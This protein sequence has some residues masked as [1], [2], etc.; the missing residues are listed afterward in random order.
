MHSCS[1]EIHYENGKVETV[2]ID[3]DRVLVG[4]GA[5]CDIRLA[6]EIGAF[7]HLVLTA[8]ESGFVARVIAKGGRAT[9][10]GAPFRTVVMTDGAMLAIGDVRLVYRECV[11]V[12]RFAGGARKKKSRFLALFAA[13]FVP[14]ATFVALHSGNAAAFGPPSNVPSPLAEPLKACPAETREQAA[15]LAREKEIVAQAKRQRWKFYTRDGV[16]AVMLF[17]VASACHTAAGNVEGAKAS[18]L[19]ATAMRAGVLQEFQVYRVRLERAIE[20][21]DARVALAQI[22]FLRD[23]L[24]SRD[25]E[26]DYVRWLTIMQRKLEAKA[27]RS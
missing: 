18:A 20:R 6:P 24:Y 27:S 13:V 7:E 3:D 19:L 11:A 1:F 2:V 22:H 26:D 5:H 10:D 25:I 8:E 23:M 12:D 9:V 15:A 16:E 17:E 14:L 21:N 4:S